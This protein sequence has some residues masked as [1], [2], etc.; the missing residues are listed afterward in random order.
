MRVQV[1]MQG[2]GGMWNNGGGGDGIMG[3]NSLGNVGNVP[4]MRGQ[5]NANLAGHHHHL[6]A[7][8]NVAG[9]NALVRAALKL[10]PNYTFRV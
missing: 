4:S 10:N 3:A 2:M 8:G 7:L 1:Q 6:Q 9:G 5:L